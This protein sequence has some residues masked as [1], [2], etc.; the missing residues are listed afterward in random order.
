MDVKRRK[1]NHKGDL[2]SSLLIFADIPMMISKI[3]K[4]TIENTILWL[5]NDENNA[6]YNN[7]MSIIY[8]IN[9]N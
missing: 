2:F 4:N 6:Y 7:A 8:T 9:V 3:C 1:D 5:I